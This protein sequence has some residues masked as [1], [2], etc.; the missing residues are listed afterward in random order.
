MKKNFLVL[1]SII[2]L[3]GVF[4]S[5]IIIINI[6]SNK[7]DLKNAPEEI[8]ID[9]QDFKL[10]GDVW[11]DFMPC[12]GDGCGNHEA[13]CSVKIII[14]NSSTFPE[15]IEAIQIWVTNQNDIWHVSNSDPA[16]SNDQYIRSGNELRFVVRNGPNTENWAEGTLVDI[17]VQ[18]KHN[19]QLYLLKASDQPIQ[20]TH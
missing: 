4:S 12:I 14:I 15:D 2:T 9:E 17:V 11:R 18:L 7:P 19:S 1:L 5:A 13:I 10:E 3:I 16:F 20:F 6:S 8:T